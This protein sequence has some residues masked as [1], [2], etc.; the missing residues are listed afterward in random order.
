MYLNLEGIVLN[1]NELNENIIID[2][3][4]NYLKLNKLFIHN[5]YLYSKIEDTLISYKKIGGVKEILFD[6]FETNIISFFTEYFPCQFDGF[7]FYYLIKTYKNK[8]ESSIDKIKNISTNKITLNFSFLEFTDGIYDLQNNNFI[9]K[10]N[11]INSSN[12][13]TIKY[14]KQAYNW[15]R[16]NKP[17]TWIN[18]IT[19]AIGKENINDFVT[20]CL[21]IASFFRPKDDTMKKKFMYIHGKTN[22]GKTTY[23]TK[24][25]TRYFGP[26]NVGNVI[27]SSDFKFQDLQNKLLVIMDEFRYSSTFSS[28][29]LKLLGGEPL[30]TNQK[31][32]KNHITIQGLMGLIL[33]N[34]LFFEKDTSTNQALLERLHII[35]FLYNVD[36]ELKNMDTNNINQLLTNEEPNIIIFC[37]KLYFSYYNN[38]L[39]Y[40]NKYKKLKSTTQNKNTISLNNKLKKTFFV[41]YSETSMWY[42]TP[43]NLLKF[44]DKTNFQFNCKINS[45]WCSKF[46]LHDNKLNDFKYTY[47]TL[48]TD[49]K[50]ILTSEKIGKVFHKNE[51]KDQ[52]VNY[53]YQI[54]TT[55]D[56]DNLFVKTTKYKEIEKANEL[57]ELLLVSDKIPIIEER[58][59]KGF[60]LFNQCYKYTQK[61]NE[62][63]QSL[64]I[65][66][67]EDAKVILKLVFHNYIQ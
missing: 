3:I 9:F 10:N 19:N 40:N 34:Y 25:L 17:K 41:K 27:N 46:I 31:Y 15:I 23:L 60:E 64:A 50:E 53:N 16:K 49:E 35:E 48:N 61:F 21:F 38:K 66:Y 6:Q 39:I 26:E 30:L 65:I 8:M 18:G 28:D 29:F 22:T 62:C 52:L 63:Y 20:I 4:L 45:H 58:L 54:I 59:S 5:D 43:R 12:I 57:H 37:N 67:G 56:T 51:W 47:L 11:F 1:K 36:K 32:S 7:D 24:V 33:S 42:C 13:C 14:Y 44:K 2:L 55:E